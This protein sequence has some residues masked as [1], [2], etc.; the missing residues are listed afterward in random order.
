[1]GE[2]CDGGGCDGAGCLVRRKRPQVHASYTRVPEFSVKSH[3]F[4]SRGIGATPSTLLAL[5]KP[6]RTIA[7]DLEVSPLALG[8]I[9]N[10]SASMLL[11]SGQEMPTQRPWPRPIAI[12]LYAI[13][14][15]HRQWANV[16]NGRLHDEIWLPET[17]EAGVVFA[18]VPECRC[19]ACRA[20][21]IQP[22]RYYPGRTPTESSSASGRAV[23]SGSSAAIVN[24]LLCDQC[25]FITATSEP[26]AY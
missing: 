5:V 18:S 8:E 17:A 22:C 6:T 11:D 10:A 12:A 16:V 20:C 3:T 4:L 19:R 13:S 23:G 15:P 26:W 9:K 21:G 7:A 14:S 1:M 25:V 2:G 24:R